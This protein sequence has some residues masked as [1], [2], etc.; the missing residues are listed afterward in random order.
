MEH[1]IVINSRG[2]I[3]KNDKQG[4][5]AKLQRLFIKGRVL[6]PEFE[7][8]SSPTIRLTDIRLRRFNMIDRT[9]HRKLI[10]KA[11]YKRMVI[12]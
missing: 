12:W 6:V 3:E 10:N 1:P 2:K 7:M 9:D 11:G 5:L 8:V 4:I